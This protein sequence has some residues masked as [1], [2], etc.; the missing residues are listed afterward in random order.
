MAQPRPEFVWRAKTIL[1]YDIVDNKGFVTHRSIRKFIAQGFQV[2]GTIVAILARYDR[3]KQ[4]YIDRV[5][6]ITCTEFWEK[7][8]GIEEQKPC[9][10]MEDLDGYTKDAS[11]TE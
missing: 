10:E 4:S 9:E 6:E 8:L 2:L 7:Y 1:F 11:C 3:A 5:R